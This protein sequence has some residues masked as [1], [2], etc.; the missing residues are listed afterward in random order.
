MIYSPLNYTGNKTKLLKEIFDILLND[1]ECF[2]DVFC[3]SALVSINSP[4]NE[5]YI[6]DTHKMSSTP[7]I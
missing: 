2:Y 5:V 7:S 1:T 3:G 4:A 6:N